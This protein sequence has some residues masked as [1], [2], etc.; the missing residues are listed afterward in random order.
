MKKLTLR[1]IVLAGIIFSGAMLFSSCSKNNSDTT[2]VSTAEAKG[3]FE[4]YMVNRDLGVALAIDDTTNVTIPLS[5]YTFRLTDSTGGTATSGTVT[6][7]N[8]TRVVAGTW[9]VDAGYN[10]ITFN[11]ADVLVPYI[12]FVSKQWQF[13]NRNS[14]TIM[15]KAADGE[16]DLLQF[17]QK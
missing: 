4:N 1:F 11:F 3:Y 12:I 14:P 17:T 2:A 8:I 16:T 10:T 9:S 6:A 5:G 7:S 15:L 13:V